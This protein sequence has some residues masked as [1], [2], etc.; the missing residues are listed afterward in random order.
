MSEKKFPPTE[1]KKRDSLLNGNYHNQPTLLMAAHLLFLMIWGPYIIRYLFEITVF[2]LNS[3][4]YLFNATIFYKQLISLILRGVVVVAFLGGISLSVWLAKRKG[5]LVFKK[6][7]S[8]NLVNKNA[9]IVKLFKGVGMRELLI[10]LTKL[11]LIC[12]LFV[13]GACAFDQIEILGFVFA[14]D[15]QPLM[16]N[17]IELYFIILIPVCLCVSVEYALIRKR[18]LDELKMSIEELKQEFKN[19]EQSA[20]S[21]MRIKELQHE[22]LMSEIDNAV[23]SS[24]AVIVDA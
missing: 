23:K 24:S 9:P 20:E 7:N 5:I 10:Q 21:K 17:T 14:V 3:E 22:L 6:R 19:S 11:F 8:G 16:K 12:A 18:R 13:L 15:L 1:K 4:Q 2:F